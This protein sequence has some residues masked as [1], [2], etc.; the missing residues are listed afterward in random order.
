M[1]LLAHLLGPAADT[2]LKRVASFV[3]LAVMIAWLAVSGVAMVFRLTL[4]RGRAQAWSNSL[5]K[6][7]YLLCYVAGIVF[8]VGS[9]VLFW[10]VMKSIVFVRPHNEV[11]YV[12]A[13]LALVLG[14][15]LLT[16]NIR[17]AKL[18]QSSIAAFKHI[19]SVSVPAPSFSMR[20]QYGFPAFE[21][22][23][24]TKA[25]CE[26]AAQ[27]GLNASF[28]KAIEG[29]CKPKSPRFDVQRA[30]FFTYIGHNEELLASHATKPK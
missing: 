5:A 26:E 24:Q 3:V 23:F 12:V 18:E 2:L 16:T 27:L 8:L 30:I 9:I 22:T 21:I 19:Y 1:L 13:S 20:Y 29:L 15:L 6:L 14:A 25:Q 11:A 17:R 4:M 10:V 28:S 7:Y